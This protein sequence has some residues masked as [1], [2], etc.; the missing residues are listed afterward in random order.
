MYKKTTSW[1]QLYVK[2]AQPL[3]PQIEIATSCIP[4]DWDH[5]FSLMKGR[6]QAYGTGP[7]P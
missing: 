1:G 2:M 6:P 7:T 5:Y 4:V 3:L